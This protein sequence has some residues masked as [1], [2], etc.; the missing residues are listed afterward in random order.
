LST[1]GPLSPLLDE[2]AAAELPRWVLNFARQEQLFSPGE[3]VLVAVSGGPDS[4]ALLHLLVGLGP[5]LGLELGVAHFDH[6]IRPDSR[7]DVHF[8]AHLARELGLA[9]HLG[10][11][12]VQALAREEKISLEMAARRLRLGFLQETCRSH[13]YEKLALGHTADDQVELFFLRL[14][15]GA[16]PEGL[17]GM[18]PAT[19]QGLVRPLL[20]VGK[21]VLV[22]WLK[23]EA[24]PFRQD[25]GNLSRAFMRNKIRLDLLPE[26]RR[27]YNPRLTEAVWRAQALLQQEERLLIRE[28]SRVWG[29][30]VEE[31]APDFYALNLARLFTLD[32]ALKTRVL[33]GVVGKVLKDQTLTAAQVAGL[34]DLARGA[35]SGGLISLRD[36]RVAR[37]GLEL[38]VFRRL[39]DPF[40]GAPTPLPGPPGEVEAFGWHWELSSSAPPP[41]GLGPPPNTAFLDLDQ[42]VFPLEARYFREGD[43]FW[44]RGAPGTR[45]LQDFLVDRKI[46]RWLRPH[47]PLVVAAG[48]VVWVAGLEVAES[49][50]VTPDTKNLLEI[51]V[52]PRDA[53]S[54]RLWEVLQ[55]CRRRV[56]D[57]CR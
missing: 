33:R 48:G 55:A 47:L 20:A 5:E 4:V 51:T 8:V 41:G 54:R 32:P 18:W 56:S 13:A 9:C 52:S 31:V 2:A 21:N 23:Q 28:T 37:A 45:K 57:H 24:L 17:K 39:P 1:A 38:H 29:A 46:P 14:L 40:K 12:E 7:E 49:A 30:V 27:G 35:R 3:R 50:R 11:G 25:P 44:P 36:C 19:P 53:S 6:G 26:L 10:Q 34:L 42:V 16:G 15:R 22:A 43:R